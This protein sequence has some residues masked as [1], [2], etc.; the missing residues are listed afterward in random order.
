MEFSGQS[1]LHCPGIGQPVSGLL[2]ILF[3]LLLVLPDDLYYHLIKGDRAITT[4]QEELQ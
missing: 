4:N 3:S 1:S 2:E